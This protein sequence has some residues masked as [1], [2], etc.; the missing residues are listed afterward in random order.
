MGHNSGWLQRL[1][2]PLHYQ[3][4]PKQ[5]A[6]IR[7]ALNAE[8]SSAEG[9]IQVQTLGAGG[10]YLTRNTIISV[11]SKS[12]LHPRNHP[13]LLKLKHSHAWTSCLFKVSS[14]CCK[15]TNWPTVCSA[16]VEMHVEKKGKMFCYYGYMI[17]T[18]MEIQ[19]ITWLE[20]T[21]YFYEWMCCTVSVWPA[22]KC[23]QLQVHNLK[24]CSFKM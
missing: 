9:F 16:G 11:T 3:L 8:T 5:T 1:S 7:T 18:N 24:F 10:H 21:T 4:H 19:F 20:N 13:W 15:Q 14:V 6:R 12:H 17:N 2:A 22:V 23:P